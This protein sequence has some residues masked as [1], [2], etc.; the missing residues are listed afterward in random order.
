MT[1]QPNFLL[2]LDPRSLKRWNQE[3]SE[4]KFFIDKRHFANSYVVAFNADPFKEDPRDAISYNIE[5]Q[6][7]SGHWKVRHNTT[8]KPV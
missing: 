5:L 4:R 1:S 7:H 8:M 3:T 6:L 2:G